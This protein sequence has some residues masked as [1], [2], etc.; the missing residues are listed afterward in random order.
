MFSGSV[1][2]AAFAPASAR[3][4]SSA[5][6]KSAGWRGKGR[7]LGPLYKPQ[8]QTIA[9]TATTER[10]E[11]ETLKGFFMLARSERRGKE[12]PHHLPGRRVWRPDRAARNIAF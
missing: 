8:V 12:S 7:V 10:M 11:K 1:S 6:R 9:R 3:S 4:S 2:R 5:G